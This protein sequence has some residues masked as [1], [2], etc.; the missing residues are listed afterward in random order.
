MMKRTVP[1]YFTCV[2]NLLLFVYKQITFSNFKQIKF[3]KNEKRGPQSG[4]EYKILN[5]TDEER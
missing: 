2:C 3:F 5:F 1:K 4:Y